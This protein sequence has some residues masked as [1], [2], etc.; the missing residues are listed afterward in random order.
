[1][2][3][4]QQMAAIEE[5]SLAHLDSLFSASHQLSVTVQ[6]VQKLIGCVTTRTWESVLY[7]ARRLLNSRSDESWFAFTDKVKTASKKPELQEALRE[8]ESVWCRAYGDLI[9]SH[10]HRFFIDAKQHSPLMVNPMKVDPINETGPRLSEL[11]SVQ[12]EENEL[13]KEV[14][15]RHRA[16]W[17]DLS[18]GLKA[19][20]K[21]R[22]GRPFAYKLPSIPAFGPNNIPQLLQSHDLYI[23]VSH[24]TPPPDIVYNR[25]G[26]D[27]GATELIVMF[28]LRSLN[29]PAAPYIPI[30]LTGGLG[31]T[32]C[33]S[34]GEPIEHRDDVTISFKGRKMGHGIVPLHHTFGVRIRCVIYALSA[35]VGKRRLC[36]RPY[37]VGAPEGVTHVSHFSIPVTV[38]TR[39]T[40]KTSK[41][42]DSSES[43]SSSSSAVFMGSWHSHDFREAIQFAQLPAGFLPHTSQVTNTPSYKNWQKLVDADRWRTMQRAFLYAA[44][45]F[46]C[47]DADV[48]SDCEELKPSMDSY[49]QFVLNRGLLNPDEQHLFVEGG[50]R[51]APIE[52]LAIDRTPA[53]RQ[54]MDCPQLPPCRLIVTEEATQDVNME[55]KLIP[56]VEARRARGRPKDIESVGIIPPF[57]LKYD[58]IDAIEVRVEQ[59]TFQPTLFLQTDL[60]TMTFLVSFWAGEKPCVITG[61]LSFNVCDQDGKPLGQS[62]VKRFTLFN[63]V[64]KNR[65]DAQVLPLYGQTSIRVRARIDILRRNVPLMPR[66]CLQ[67]YLMDCPTPQLCSFTLPVSVMSRFSS[68]HILPAQVPQMQQK[69][70]DQQVRPDASMRQDFCRAMRLLCTKGWRPQNSNW[71]R[72]CKLS[73][74]DQLLI[75][76]VL[77]YSQY[78][79]CDF[80]SAKQAP[81]IKPL[82]YSAWIAAHEGELRS[83]NADDE[84]L[85][86]A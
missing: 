74:R 68:K 86:V 53:K 15:Q 84:L 31:F 24:L 81:T 40:S 63:P 20:F 80:Y 71:R 10:F 17:K 14:I 36:L 30:Q 51:S 21:G 45:R 8:Y 54:K 28:A 32:V 16:N 26:L 29:H 43:S 57:E 39:K 42:E 83:A 49:R 67:P 27:E 79:W 18:L 55:Q 72:T 22:R 41:K 46:P 78:R 35:R 3:G 6:E 60:S 70:K 65:Y 1:M 52:L 58:G 56:Q 19:I 23:F 44:V 59:D 9:R 47:A 66:L 4:Q 37:L 61:A 38:K 34:T 2:F 12:L 25:A 7:E 77:T 73:N 33:T 62:T 5:A 11:F 76:G 75:R 48:Q 50:K 69:F 82:V 64:A 85:S 13:T